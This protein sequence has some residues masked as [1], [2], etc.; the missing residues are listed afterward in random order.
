[1]KKIIYKGFFIALMGAAFVGC[2]KVDIMPSS[3]SST[4]KIDNEKQTLIGK[5]RNNP[6][7]I[8]NMREAYSSLSKEK[9]SN[10]LEANKLYVRFLPMDV[11]QLSV[12][13]ADSLILSDIPLDVEVTQYGAI[14]YDASTLANGTT[15]LY[16][17]VD[18]NYEFGTTQ[19]EIIDSL[20]LPSQGNQGQKSTNLFSEFTPEQLEDKALEIAGYKAEAGNSQEK[21]QKYNPEGYVKVQQKINSNLTSV[22]VKNLKVRSRWWFDYGTAYTDDN[23]HFYIDEKYRKNRDVNII[24]IF[25]NSAVNIRT[26]KGTQFW[27]MFF[28]ERHNIGEFE[29]SALENINYTFNNSSDVNSNTKRLWMACHAINSVR[30]YRVYAGQNGIGMPPLH[31]NLWLTNAN[32]NGNSLSTYAAAPM[33]K[34]MSNSSLLVNGVQL[35][36]VATGHPWFAVA[37]Q[38]LEQYPPDITY[39]Y[40]GE[41]AAANDNSDEISQTFY[42]ELAHA[43]HYNKVGNIYWLSYISY[44]VQHSGYGV[45]T[46]SGSGRIAISEAWAEFCGAHFAHLR[47]GNNFSI[48]ETWISYIENFEPNISSGTWNWIPD[49]VMHDLLDGGEPGFTDVFDK[50]YGY[51]IQQCYGSL[52]PD[53]ITVQSYKNRFIL[54]SGSAQQDNI[55]SLFKTYGY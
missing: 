45:S 24:F 6:F 52:D 42:H 19:Y 11:A 49:G 34:Q 31:L 40:S 4:V 55:H 1:M 7:T 41:S 46:D 14:Y 5:K 47:Y 35:F 37:I 12:L 28:T 13:D 43:T 32:T 50:V 3:S 29:N 22:P 26:I 21:V 51:S 18:I 38:V 17:T 25:E 39:N 27:D 30:E 16:T 15:W 36:L 54:E 53:I 33:L 10:Q 20:Y 8:K 2:K 48:G 44:I 9:S 23:G